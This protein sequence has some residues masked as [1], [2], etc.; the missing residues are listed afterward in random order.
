[1][2]VTM[3]PKKTVVPLV[4]P[5]H[6]HLRWSAVMVRPN[7]WKWLE[8]GSMGSLSPGLCDGLALVIIYRW[9]PPKQFTGL[10]VNLSDETYVTTFDLTDREKRDVL[11]CHVNLGHPHPKEF[12]RLLRAAGSRHD[13]TQYVLREFECPGCVREKRS[14]SRL[15]AATPRT[16]DFNVVIG[17]DL[18]FV[19][20][21]G[22]RAEHPVLNVTCLGTLYSTFG[23]IDPLAKTST[24]TWEGFTRLWLRTF[25]APQYLMF[26]EGREFTGGAFQEGMERRGIVPLEVARQAPFA[27]GVV[28]RRGGLF[29]EVYY[30][31]IEGAHAA[32]D[33][34]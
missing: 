1:M 13:V 20:G 32:Y 30:R 18:L 7:E 15:P 11:R 25:G 17:V 8:R 21:L 27:N 12:A 33:A 23:L 10:G 19:H 29:K 22:S 34:V 24:K 4:G 3:C 9:A 5:G 16:Y 28:E 2:L 31:T 14:P 6:R 26:D